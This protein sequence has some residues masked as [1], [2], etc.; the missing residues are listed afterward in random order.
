MGV[1]G[2]LCVS[3]GSSTVQFHDSIGSR[4]AYAYW[5]AGFSSQNGDHAWEVYY[6][7][8]SFCCAFLLWAKKR[9]C[10]HRIFIKKCFLCTV[11]S[12]YLVKR[13]TTR[14]RN[15]LKDVRKS[16]IMPDQVRQWLRQQ[17]KDFY[18]EG[19]DALVKRCDKCISVGGGYAEK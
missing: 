9:N 19:F 11:G 17:S 3:L 14:S 6:R 18:A 5:E 16:Q 8:A 10:M 12:V 13:F 15:S 7:T 4:R 2:F 1:I